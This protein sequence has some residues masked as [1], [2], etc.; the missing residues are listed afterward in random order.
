[1]VC[2]KKKQMLK[3]I[4]FFSLWGRTV[5]VLLHFAIKIIHFSKPMAVQEYAVLEINRGLLRTFVL[6]RPDGQSEIQYT[7]V[8]AL[9]AL[10]P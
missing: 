1:M 3:T 6:Y 5:G 2:L 9:P 8:L 10:L 4:S 7:G